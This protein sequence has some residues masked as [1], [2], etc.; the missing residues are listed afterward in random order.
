MSATSAKHQNQMAP[1]APIWEEE[2]LVKSGVEA[3]EALT[4]VASVEAGVAT[5]VVSEVGEAETEATSAQ[6]KW[7]PEGTT[8]RIAVR[9]HTKP[10]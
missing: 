9:D 8:D 5:E 4:E 10:V 6:E 2:D 1:G 3:E 7:I